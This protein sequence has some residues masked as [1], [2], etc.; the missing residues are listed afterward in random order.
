MQKLKSLFV[1]FIVMLVTVSY[2]NSME[3]KNMVIFGDSLSDNGNFFKV[4]GGVYP[5]A[6]CYQGRYSDGPIWFEYLAEEIG[7]TG[8]NLNY[9]HVGA[10]TGTTN[11]DD[12]RVD[13]PFPGFLTEIQAYLDLAAI[14]TKYPVTFAMPEDTLFLIWIGGNDFWGV[15]GPEDAA[16][17]IKAAAV[18]LQTGLSQLINAGASKFLVMNLPDLG[19][20]PTYN[21]DAV[22]SAMASQISAGYNQALEQVLSGMESAYTNI[23]I[24]RVDTVAAVKDFITNAETFG[25]INTS[26]EKWK[27]SDNTIAEGNYLFWSGGHPTTF[28]HKLIAQKVAEAITCEN[29]KG[30]ITPSVSSDFTITIPSAKIGDQSVGFTLMHYKNATETGH[31]WKLD[32]DSVKVK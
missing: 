21:K 23:T 29:C 27:N 9:A 8:L 6:A 24:K 22:M 31:F 12:P 10:K 4:S 14:A 2:A 19:V 25:F 1:A 7:A 11:Y 18:N 32:M 26:D 28:T 5:P 30:N 15:T 3:F 20:I 16:A 13:K 17:R